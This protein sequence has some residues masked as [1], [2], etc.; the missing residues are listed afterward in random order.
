MEA[1]SA[2]NGDRAAQ[3]GV[4]PRDR[5][6]HG[7]LRNALIEAATG[8]AREGGP[9]AV[10]LRAAARRV[11]VSPT[12][13]YRHFEGQADLLD[14]VKQYGQRHL[15]ETMVEAGAA[16]EGEG[17]EAAVARIRA[18]GRGYVRFAVREPGL[19]STAFG[20]TEM[21]PLVVGEGESGGVDP[22]D[23]PWRAPAFDMLAASLDALL[24]CGLMPPERRPG[25][26]VSAWAMA[27]GLATLVLEGPLAGLPA[28]T[29]ERLVERALSDLVAGLTAPVS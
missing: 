4:R 1:K 8:L 25:A 10:V 3:G 22:E 21:T 15:A 27:H 20:G 2:E 5:Y 16:I 9:G 11:G 6:H 23:Q 29:F 26:E 19:F 14:E 18:L 17:P 13:A 24:A 12:A 28:D 7:D